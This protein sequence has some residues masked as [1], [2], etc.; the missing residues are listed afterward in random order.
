[1]QGKVGTEQERLCKECQT[2]INAEM[3]E[4]HKEGSDF[5]FPKI[6]QLLHFGEQIRRYGSLKQW[7]TETGK[8]S[9][10]T[11]L[12]DLYNKLNQWDN[13]YSQMIEYYQ[14]SNAFTI[15]RLNMAVTRIAATRG[16]NVKS[17]QDA[18]ED[19]LAGVKFTSEQSSSRQRKI[20]TFATLLESVHDGSHHNELRQGTNNFLLS[21]KIQISRED[22]LQCG[23]NVYQGIRIPLS[24]MYGE[25]L[26]QYV[27]CTGEKS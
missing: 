5:K 11:Q 23:V 7:S 19:S 26:T 14:W 3:V 17:G 4:Y 12:K 24:N 9:H 13:V 8:S 10:H 16:D 15:R 27:R 1:M 21:R 18:I 25:Q 6:G 20:I 22:L 2:F